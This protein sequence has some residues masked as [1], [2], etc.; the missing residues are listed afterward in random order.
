MKNIINQSNSNNRIWEKKNTI[1]VSNLSKNSNCFCGSYD[2]PLSTPPYR[3]GMPQLPQTQNLLT[4]IRIVSSNVITKF[5]SHVNTKPLHLILSSDNEYLL[6]DD[7]LFLT[8][9]CHM[10]N[11][12]HFLNFFNTG[13]LMICL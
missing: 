6:P 8:I 3:N 11:A 4:L 2:T 1:S 7:L 9:R 10:V 5:C 13:I 12:F